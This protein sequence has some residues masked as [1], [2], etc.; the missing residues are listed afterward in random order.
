MAPTSLDRISRNTALLLVNKKPPL[1]APGGT[2]IAGISLTNL[3]Q[4]SGSLLEIALFVHAYGKPNLK[5]RQLHTHHRMI[6][7]QA[8]TITSGT[9][10]SKFISITC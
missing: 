10:I 9:L 4:D 2:L 8:C 3:L 1:T 5:A 7:V 6:I